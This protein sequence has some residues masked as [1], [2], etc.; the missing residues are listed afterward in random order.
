MH[1]KITIRYHYI[2]TRIT[3]IKRTDIRCCEGQGATENPIC[4]WVYAHVCLVMS[5]SVTPWTVAHQAP[6]STEF[7][8]QEHWSGLPFPTPGN[9][10]DP[11][12]ESTS[13]VSPALAGGFLTIGTIWEAHLLLMGMKTGA[14]P[15]KT[16]L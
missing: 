11:G 16:V 9:L 3:R 1:I 12:I 2:H 15:L 6:L 10:P 8:R 14:A 7:S 13:L 5:D 4:C